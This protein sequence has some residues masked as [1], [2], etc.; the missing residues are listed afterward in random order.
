MQNKK[1]YIVSDY[2][3]SINES[4]YLSF[5][6]KYLTDKACTPSGVGAMYFFDDLGEGEGVNRYQ[7]C[8]WSSGSKV[9]GNIF[10]E[11]LE[12]CEDWLYQ[13]KEMNLNSGMEYPA[14]F[15]TKEEAEVYKSEYELN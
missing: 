8:H 9:R 12:Q 13:I 1:I 3:Y 11:T 4:D 7:I 2:D 15:D 14:F 10:K 5:L 6:D